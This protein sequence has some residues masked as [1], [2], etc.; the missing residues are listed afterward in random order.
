MIGL[1][2]AVA[3]LLPNA[4]ARTVEIEPSDD[5]WVYPFA[6]DQVED[7]FLRVWGTA[8]RSLPKA[9]DEEGSWSYSLLSFNTKDLQGKVKSAKLVLTHNGNA[10]FSAA[11]SEAA[12]LEARTAPSGFSE[13]TWQY[14]DWTKFRPGELLGQSPAKPLGDGKPFVI[15]ID[16][17][18]APAKLAE[19][20]AKNPGK[21]LAI[22]LTGKLDPTE[23]GQAGVYKLYSKFATPVERRPKLVLELE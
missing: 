22:A 23:L 6:F 2:A 4:S 3:I 15:T 17:M 7:P 5:V 18:K 8:G 14:E 20:L 19:I 9:D 13:K 16:L 21:P 10:G 12:P 1:F 11:Q